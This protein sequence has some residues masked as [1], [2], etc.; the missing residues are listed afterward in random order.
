VKLC[1]SIEALRLALPESCNLSVQGPLV[2]F[3]WKSPSSIA[4]R[5]FCSNRM[6]LKHARTRSADAIESA[7]EIQDYHTPRKT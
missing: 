3:P 2:E 4:T 1:A 7:I 6:S 5:Q